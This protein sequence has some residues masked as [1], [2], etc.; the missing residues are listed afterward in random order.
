M[1][2]KAA[3]PK[4]PRPANTSKPAP[5]PAGIY[6]PGPDELN[7]PPNDLLKYMICLYGTKG[8]GKSTLASTFPNSL[9][10][11]T[12]TIRKGLRIRMA[13][14]RTYT[15]EQ[16]MEGAPDTFV[17]VGERID[18]ILGD[19]TIEVLNIDSIDLFYDMVVH[20]VSAKWEVSNPSVLGKESS[21]CWIDIRNTFKAFMD[22][23]AESPLGIV[24]ISHSKEREIEAIDGELTPMISP[25]CAPACLQYI[26]QAC[27][28]AMFYGWHNDKRVIMVR[29]G[30]NRAWCAAGPEGHFMQPDGKPLNM[31]EIPDDPA[32]G[33]KTLVKAFDNKLYD[34]QRMKEESAPKLPTKKG[35]PKKKSK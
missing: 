21:G 24:L 17:Q 12:E 33:Y 29:D 15:A 30:L 28:Y 6:I 9:T 35:P 10:L 16:I 32:M 4:S 34:S 14:L 26:K 18:Q 27:D 23:L 5:A 22:L 13:Q 11:M 7:E 31:F 3:R 2:K 19:G 1:A 25:S 8:I 20:H